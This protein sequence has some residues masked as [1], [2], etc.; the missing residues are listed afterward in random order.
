[1]LLQ[2]SSLK[3][4]KAARAIVA[5][6]ITKSTSQVL[7]YA[8]CWICQWQFLNSNALL[9]CKWVCEGWCLPWYMHVLLGDSNVMYKY[10]VLCYIPNA[11]EIVSSK[12]LLYICLM[13]LF[14]LLVLVFSHTCSRTYKSIRSTRTIRLNKM[15]AKWTLTLD[16]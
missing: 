5:M 11:K 9:I 15:N 3:T 7:K 13:F 1:M 6:Q 12:T 8:H 16:I 4:V 2:E 14:L 10:K